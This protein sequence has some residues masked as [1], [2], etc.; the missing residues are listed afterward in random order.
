MSTHHAVEGLSADMPFAE[1]AR[2]M[3][4]TR[5][6]TM[7]RCR[8]GTV[9]GD[10]EALHDMRV[11]SR[12]LR[13]A[14]DMAAPAFSG[15]EYKTFGRLTQRLTEQLGAVRDGDVLLQTLDALGAESGIDGRVATDVMRRLVSASH[16]LDRVRLIAFFDKLE[17][18]GYERL[19][20]RLWRDG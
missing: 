15:K 8:D 6:E 4:W 11:G 2:K 18:A 14:L 1:A 13:A 3:V 10:V 20:K 9:A 16:D 12:R 17:A 19:A 5:F 7:W